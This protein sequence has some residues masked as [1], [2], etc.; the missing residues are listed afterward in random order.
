MT[1]RYNWKLEFICRAIPETLGFQ[2]EVMP[3]GDI[4]ITTTCRDGGGDQ[5]VLCAY[6]AAGEIAFHDMGMM[7]FLYGE[8]ETAEMIGKMPK[9]LHV[10]M[11]DGKVYSAPRP[12][13]KPHRQESGE[14]EAAALQAVINLI[15]M[16]L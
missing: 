8:D 10:W 1:E 2:Y 16:L 15:F 9:F 5:I 7:T 6:E 4:T 14:H 3:N 12:L 11:H 13:P